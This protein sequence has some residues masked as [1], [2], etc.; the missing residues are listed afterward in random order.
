MDPATLSALTAGAV[1]IVSQYLAK[2]ADAVLPKAAEDIY[3]AIHERFSKKPAAAEVL[4]DLQS[5]PD[6]ADLQAAVRAQ[7]KK[8]LAEDEEF[9]GQLEKL[10]QAAGRGPQ[11]GVSAANRGVAAGGNIS[12]SVFT[13]DVHGPVS[14]GGKTPDGE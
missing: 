7:L 11:P 2:A 14:I 12:G 3:A 6:D 1:T 4:Q 10:V 5:A 9:A 13:G 8:T